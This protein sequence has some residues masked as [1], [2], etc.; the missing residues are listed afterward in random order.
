MRPDPR[1]VHCTEAE[2][3]HAEGTHCLF[4]PTE[5]QA[6]T[7]REFADW[8]TSEGALGPVGAAFI[9]S[10]M[11]STGFARKILSAEVPE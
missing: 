4:M 9:R 6:M 1:C 8:C 2:S 10:V 7:E 11:Y 3:Q 5:F